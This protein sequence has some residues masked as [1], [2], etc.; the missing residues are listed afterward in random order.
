MRVGGEGEVGNEGGNVRHTPQNDG[1]DAD[2]S[3]KCTSNGNGCTTYLRVEDRGE[4]V[5]QLLRHDHLALDGEL[6]L[7]QHEAHFGDDVLESLN[8]LQQHNV[9]R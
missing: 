7:R 9:Q 6:Q 3:Q 8:L 2:P 4:G 5:L 1:T